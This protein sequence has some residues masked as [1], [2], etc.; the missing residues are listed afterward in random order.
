MRHPKNRLQRFNFLIRNQK[1]SKEKYVWNCLI[2]YRFNLKKMFD[3]EW[4]SYIQYLKDREEKMRSEYP[5][6]KKIS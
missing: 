5:A 6:P 2:E 3:K 4:D 1:K